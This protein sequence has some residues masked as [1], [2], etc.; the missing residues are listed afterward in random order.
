MGNNNS[1][2]INYINPVTKGEFLYDTISKP[3]SSSSGGSSKP[4][5]LDGVDENPITASDN[6]WASF[7]VKF[8]KVYNET[9]H[10]TTGYTPD[11]ARDGNNESIIRNNQ[12][13]QEYKIKDNIKTPHKI[14]DAVRVQIEHGTFGKHTKQK[15]SNE[16]YL[17]TKVNLTN[18]ITYKIKDKYGN[19]G[20]H[21][22]Y[23][24]QL[25]KSNLEA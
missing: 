25:L 5:A 1:N 10:A 24:H 4:F 13:I 2:P 15:W 18:P 21:N 6:K 17:I 3:F 23:H 8:E 12:L 22:F 7:V 11:E 20:H 16:L 19:E 14:G 9:K